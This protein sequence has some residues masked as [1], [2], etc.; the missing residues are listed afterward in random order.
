MVDRP[1]ERPGQLDRGGAFE[2]LGERTDELLACQGCT[3]AE[4]RA[5]TEG[6]MLWRFLAVEIELV[7]VVEDAGVAVRC[8]VPDHHHRT[9]GNHD[10]VDLDVLSRPSGQAL[11]GTLVAEH[12]L[13]ERRHE[14]QIAAD[15]RLHIRAPG[16]Q[17]HAVVEGA[18]G[19][20]ESPGDQLVHQVLQFGHAQRLGTVFADVGV[21]QRRDQIVRRLG[22][23]LLEHR[24]EVV[25]RFELDLDRLE[26][27]VLGERSHRQRQHRLSPTVEPVDLRAI[28]AELLRNDD[29]GQRH[30]EVH[31]ELAFA[32]RRSARR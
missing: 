24:G 26:Q 32:W 19:G 12:F 27:F 23:T 7:G 10:T 8:G 20:L 11:H 6:Q 13:D 18:G 3:D 28:E 5:D 15:P 30:R 17:P 22:A 1:V 16:E 9:L 31:V 2:P 29:A 25:L 14:R 4:V 21:H